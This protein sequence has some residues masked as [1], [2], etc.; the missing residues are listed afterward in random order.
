MDIREIGPGLP[1]RKVL[2]EALEDCGALLVVIGRGWVDAKDTKGKR[3]LENPRDTLRREV[4]EALIRGVRVFPLLVNGAV[5]PDE[6]LL[7]DDIQDLIDLQGYELTVRHWP[8]D[9]AKLI[10]ILKQLPALAEEPIAE[11]DQQ[12][13][14]EE[15]EA[16]ADFATE[17]PYANAVPATITDTAIGDAVEILVDGNWTQSDKSPTDLPPGTVFRDGVGTPEMVVIPAGTFQMGSLPSEEGRK[18]KEGPLHRVTIAGSFAVGRYAVTFDEWDLFVEATGLEYTPEDE[19]WGRGNRPVINVNWDDA[20]AYVQWLSQHTSREY[21]LLSEAEWE[22]AARAGRTSRYPWGYK[23][24]RNLANFFDSGSK[25]SGS[26][27]APVGSFAPNAFGLYD[28][29]GNV[30]EWVEDCR[31]DD[32]RGAPTDG[33]AWVSGDCEARVLRGGSFNF[34]AGRA[35]SACRVG[36]LPDYRNYYIGFRVLYSSPID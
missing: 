27:T 33:S 24:G 7:P 28:M 13:K 19:G 32:Y 30:W 35:R 26:K 14:D 21:R 6:D 4:A 36:R 3:R 25:W 20:K 29:I 2:D 22:Y 9:V 18:D 12:E 10:A 8:E 1:W 5:M 31:H 34:L 11:Q 15:G 23:R 16:N 17:T